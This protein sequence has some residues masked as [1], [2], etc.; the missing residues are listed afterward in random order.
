MALLISRHAP[1]EFHSSGELRRYS[2]QFSYFF[3][4]DSVV[5]Q[6]QSSWRGEDRT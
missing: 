3:D 6:L 1:D 2:I 4:P 5:H